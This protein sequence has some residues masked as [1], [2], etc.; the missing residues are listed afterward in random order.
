M[1]NEERVC[2][3]KQVL[4]GYCLPVLRR[5]GPDYSGIENVN[6][7]FEEGAERLGVDKYV[8]WAVYFFKH[9]MALE[10]WLKSRKLESEGLEGRLTDLINYLFILWSMLAEDKIISYPERS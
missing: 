4:E 10:S 1:T 6:H 3:V 9:M 7:N 2:F 8:I 5:K